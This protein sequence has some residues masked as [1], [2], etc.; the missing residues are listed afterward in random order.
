MEHNILFEFGIVLFVGFIAALL[1][2]KIGQSVIIGYILAGLFIGPHC[3]KLVKSTEFLGNLSEFGIVFLMFFLGLEFSINKFKKIKNVVLFIGTYEVFLNLL[4]GFITGLIIGFSFKERLFL[5]CIIALSSSGVVAKLLFEMKKTASKESEIL[6][7]VMVFEDFIAIVILGILSSIAVTQNIKIQTLVVSIGSAMIFYSIFIFI[8]VF[9][10]N[11]FI[12]K[13]LKITSQELFTA[14]MLSLILLISAFAH[15]IGIASAAGA[16]LLGMIIVSYDVEER[17]HRTVSAFKDIF[18]LVFFISFGMLLNPEKIPGVLWLIAIFVPVTILGELLIT[19]S[20]AYFS[21][22][23]FNKSISIGASMISRG[24]YSML[25][26]TIGFGTGAISENLYQFT[27]LYVFIMTLIAP[28]AMKNSNKIKSVFSFLFPDFA[29]ARCAMISSVLNPVLMPADPAKQVQHNYK[30]LGLFIIY[31]LVSLYS[32]LIK[33][34]YLVTVL[35]LLNMLLVFLL[36]KSFLK[37][38]SSICNDICIIHPRIKHYQKD[39]IIEYASNIVTGFLIFLAMSAAVWS[40]SYMY[41]IVALALFL[42]YIGLISTMIKK[43]TV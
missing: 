26:A 35:F 24:E 23:S 42:I 28:V 43:K 12:D 16:F 18:L 39:S 6:M 13:L 10:I 1:T 41:L 37:K 22:F 7:G 29:K 4:L 3:L 31:A 21:G 38:I 11:K 32:I 15:Y 27:G 36:N 25:Y 34:L 19:S 17:I 2:K 40:L 9:V 8:G 33:N 20:S 30:I 14:L 5:S